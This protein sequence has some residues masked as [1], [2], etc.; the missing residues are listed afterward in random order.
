[1]DYPHI[2]PLDISDEEILEEIREGVETRT[3]M[4]FEEFV[5]AYQEGTLPDE[6][7][8]NELKML[9]RFVDISSGIDHLPGAREDIG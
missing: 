1:M 4:T 9:L 6:L 8:E 7:A 2:E 3:N 5:K